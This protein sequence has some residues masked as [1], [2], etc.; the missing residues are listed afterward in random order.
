M[1]QKE[2]PS[3]NREARIT[4]QELA[5]SL[6]ESTKILRDAAAD[7]RVKAKARG[8]KGMDVGDVRV[9]YGYV[10]EAYGVKAKILDDLAEKLELDAME[11][12]KVLETEGDSVKKNMLLQYE[13]LKIKFIAHVYAFFNHIDDLTPEDLDYDKLQKE[14]AEALREQEERR[15]KKVGPLPQPRP[16]KFLLRMM[17]LSE[18]EIEE[19]L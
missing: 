19:W 6:A 18:K 1:N 14:A 2:S 12:I 11:T 16:P 7:L 9:G 15:K 17:G 3:E 8:Y 4:N 13:L 10:Q 5:R